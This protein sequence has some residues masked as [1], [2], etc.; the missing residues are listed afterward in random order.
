M[1]RV[2]I[3]IVAITLFFGCST[4]MKMT[5]AKLYSITI[6]SV[7]RIDGDIIVSRLLFYRDGESGWHILTLEKL[8]GSSLSDQYSI[9]CRY[10]GS[11]WE[12]I[13]QLK[14][15]TDTGIL[16][17]IDD[18]PSHEIS[19]SGGVEELAR[20][21]LLPDVVQA[22]KETSKLEFQY[23]GKY[24]T[25]PKAVPAEGISAIRSFLGGK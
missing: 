20:F 13:D 15:K 10:L 8:A 14:I 22:I 9:A 24:R 21:L 11:T 23:F 12:F 17:F 3:L 19:E 2:A 25:Q 5:V 18:S 16:S 7:Q 4:T 1:K 6:E